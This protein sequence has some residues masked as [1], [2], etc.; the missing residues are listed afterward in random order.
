MGA[1]RSETSTIA[2]FF[3]FKL[4]YA[5]NREGHIFN[6]LSKIMQKAEITTPKMAFLF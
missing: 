3:Y 2:E 6:L 1:E 4:G 5:R